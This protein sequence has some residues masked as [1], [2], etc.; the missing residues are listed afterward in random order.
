MIDPQ[1]IRTASDKQA[2]A[3][4]CTFDI[5]K[6]EKVRDF[7]SRFLRHSKGQW[8]GKPFS[9]LDWQWQDVIAPL[10]GWRRPDG[11][12]R[13]QRV[14]IEVAKKQGK[15]AMMSGL[16]LYL[17]LG[18]GE[19]GAEVYSAAADRDQASIIFNE[20]ANMVKA[21]PLK[22]HLMVIDSRKQIAYPKTHSIYKALSAE[23]ATK[24]GLNASAIL[25]DE[26]HAQPNRE[27]W[28]TLR[29]ATRARQQ[30]LA[31]SITTA[32]YD[33]HSIC[34]EQHQYAKGVIEGTIIDPDFLA[35]IYAAD[36]KDD[37]KLPATWRKAN[38]SLG[39]TVQEETLAA[40]CREAIESPAKENSFRRYTL[41]QWTEQNTRWLA[42][43]KWDA[44]TGKMD[45]EDLLGMRCFAGLDMASTTDLAAFVLDFPIGEG[46]WATLPWF[47]SPAET[48]HK[49][50]LKDKVPYE[51]W[52]KQGFMEVTE[53]NIVDYDVIR[54]RIGEI[55]KQYNIAEI[56]VDRWNSTQLQT[57]LFGDG[58]TVVPFGQGFA[59]MSAPTKEL[60]KLVLGARLVH[61][62]NPVLRWMAS[63][64]S[65]KQ[66]AA[67]NMKPD[68]EVSTEK[69]D[70]IVA[71]VMGLGRGIL[72]PGGGSVYDTRGLVT[73]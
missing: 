32:G 47:W 29:F 53:G 52:I 46:R 30:P 59:S 38:P 24:E 33:R 21:S 39:V 55:G 19:S 64:V 73:V 16:A 18:D 23:V 27:L 43:D 9:F 68:K 34:W 61:F 4:G 45:R 17:L 8:A 2:E 70:G 42:L 10:F 20:S 63:N 15:S 13:F 35:V 60:E 6:A 72:A 67:G 37:W 1:C 56:A 49:R 5:S 65:I 26:L 54:R 3:D 58:F 44:C 66:D 69:I 12:R 57:Q 22:H 14:Y 71:M 36:E 31:I 11:R 48:A 28:D 25:F 40:D 51:T 41:N 62:G 7:F 50:S